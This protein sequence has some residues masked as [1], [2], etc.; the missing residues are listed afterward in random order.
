MH[1]DNTMKVLVVDDFS[2]MRAVVVNLFSELGFVNV[3]QAADGQQAWEII[4]QHDFFDLIVC[5]WNMPCMTGIELLKKLKANPQYCQSKF[6]LI[7]AE[8]KSAQILE[9]SRSGAD[10][11]ILKPF[12]LETLHEKIFEVFK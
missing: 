1:I 12:S 2:T 10:G 11:Y 8:A 5:D 4:Q 9:A 6:I 3:H 7:T